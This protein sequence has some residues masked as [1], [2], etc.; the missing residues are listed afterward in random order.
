M[1][2]PQSRFRRFFRFS[3][4]LYAFFLIPTLL[5]FLYKGPGDANLSRSIGDAWQA[6]FWHFPGLSETV[7]R[8]VMDA[9]TWIV[10][11]LVTWLFYEGYCLLNAIRPSELPEF[12][13]KILAWV[14]ISALV[15]LAVIPFHS[16]DLYG[17]LN[18]GFQQSA[19]HT[20]PYLTPIANIPNWQQLS[21][22]HAHWQY[23]PCPYGFFFAWW[24]KCITS[25]ANHSFVFAFLMMKTV[26]VF[27]LMGTTAL[28]VLLARQLNQPRPWLSAYLW[29]A[30]P[31]VLLQ[32][33]G[34]G[35]NDIMMVF[36]LL[37]AFTALLFPAWSVLVLPLLMLSV[38]VKYASI[39]A[40]PFVLVYL[41][42]QRQW[43]AL[44]GGVLISIGLVY[45]LALPYVSSGEAWPWH[46]L[47]DNAG[48]SQHSLAD[49]IARLIYYPAK[50][51][52][53]PNPKHV[54]ASALIWIKLVLFGGFAVFCA[55]MGW[56]F[57]QQKQS[58]AKLIASI[59]VVMTLLVTVVS[60]KFH[61][62]YVVMFLPLVL[63]LPESTR[64]RRFGIW[65]SVFQIAG[66]TL[67]Q[68][69]HI[70]NVLVL[71]LLP[72]YL[73]LRIGDLPCVKRT[74]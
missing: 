74:G 10:V 39:L 3:M 9:F 57:I 27:F 19:Y 46:A 14:G 22:L 48:K 37:L 28:I 56:Q 36:L 61:P 21:L 63:V 59:A 18:R 38:L 53:I 49:L 32:V 12:R 20:N 31:L 72:L 62:W 7:S 55:W 25:M 68:N 33:M 34:N 58:F 73:S 52:H 64:L 67:L 17:Y 51:L 54:M 29:G 65:F 50:L 35:H 60:A 11:G 6:S 41:I 24:V 66:F 4:G 30:N 8:Y 40:V 42:Q 47:L 71:T 44:A 2:D 23:N 43:K 45:V 70:L 69:V 26:N 16:S 5:W 13:K 15:L 1:M